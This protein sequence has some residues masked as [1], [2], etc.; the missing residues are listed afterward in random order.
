M[1]QSFGS[2]AENGQPNVRWRMERLFDSTW[3]DYESFKNDSVVFPGAAFFIISRD[4]GKSIAVSNVQ[5]ARSDQMSTKGIPLHQGWNL[6]GDP[7][8]VNIPYILIFFAGGSLRPVIITQEP[9]HS[10]DGRIKCRH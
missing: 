4:S 6:V 8:A 2:D 3:E 7:F 5:L 9:I 1:E 10:V